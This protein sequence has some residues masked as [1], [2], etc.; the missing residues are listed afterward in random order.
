MNFRASLLKS[1]RLRGFSGFRNFILPANHPVVDRLRAA[2]PDKVAIRHV[3]SGNTY[4]YREM[5]HDLGYW[6]TKLQEITKNNKSSRIA[7]MGENSYQFAVA[8][9][10][11]LTLPQTL[12]VPLCTNHTAAEIKYQLEDSQATC[13]ITPDRFMNKVAQF[14]KNDCQ[15]L[16]FEK[17]QP[18]SRTAKGSQNLEAHEYKDISYDEAGYMLYTSGTSGNPKGV[19][20][21]LA[22]FMAQAKALSTAW[23]INEETNF[24]H[25]LPLHHVH[26]I[27]IALTLPILAGGRV[28]FLFPFSPQAVLARISVSPESLPPINTYTAVPTIYSKIIEYVDHQVLPK[29]N[30]AIPSP[31]RA[32][33]E[34]LKLAMCGSAALPD[35]LRNSWDRVTENLIPLLERYGMTETGITLSQPLEPIS[36]RRSGTVGHPVPSVV[37]QIMDRE[38]QKVLYDSSQPNPPSEEVSGDLLLGGPTVFQEYWGKPEATRDTFLQNSQGIWFVT[39]DVAS[40][41]PEDQSIKILGRASMDIIKSGGEKLS[42]LEI[43]REILGIPH[44]AETAVV[45]IPSK[46]W[47]EQAIAIVVLTKDAVPGYRQKFTQQFLKSQ[48]K[49]K[50]SGY[51][52]PKEVLVLDTPIPRNQMGKVN[53]K[54]LVKE[55]F[56]H[57]L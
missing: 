48:L 27:L 57:R 53:K 30:G 18:E 3:P 24:L 23:K 5:L 9:Y 56:S 41:N 52:I 47:G 20:T 34:R 46:E 8:F 28:E 55:L 38:S 16:S 26:G 29:N 54:S 19:V 17:L 25:T 22:T 14:H 39:G 15:V 43:E 49:E 10:A 50:L 35:P 7:I 42:A 33:F 37:A 40:I 51:K 44:I 4:T 13:V 36:S 1:P 12:V 45:G 2:D 6:R 32:G 11:S 21:P 31:L